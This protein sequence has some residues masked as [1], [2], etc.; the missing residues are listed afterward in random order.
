MDQFKATC[1]RIR[2][3]NGIVQ[4]LFSCQENGNKQ[5]QHILLN[6]HSEVDKYK[7]DKLYKITIEEEKD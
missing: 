7:K 2:R 6:L 3:N 5:E 4:I 1:R